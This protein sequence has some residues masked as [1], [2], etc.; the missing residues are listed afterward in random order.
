MTTVNNREDFLIELNKLLPTNNIGVEIGCLYGDFSQQIL[1]IIA[2]EKLY[3]I[4][5]YSKGKT[6]YSNGLNTAYSTDEDYKNIIKRFYVEMFNNQISIYREFSYDVVDR[7]SDNSFDFIY[8]DSSH[9]Y[10]DVKQDLNDWLPKLKQEGFM[11]LHDYAEIAD[12]GV[13]KATDEFLEE[14]NFEKVI[15]NTNGGDIALKRK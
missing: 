8:I 15:F 13:I 7:F 5:P 6:E 9:I 14:H 12:F 10:P 11:C 1:D 4:D 3:L 2:P